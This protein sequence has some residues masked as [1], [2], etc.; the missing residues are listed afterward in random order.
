VAAGHCLQHHALRRVPGRRGFECLDALVDAAAD[1]LVGEVAEPAFHL[2]IQE[3]AVGVKWTWKRGAGRASSG[4][5]GSCACRSCRRPGTRPGLPGRFLSILFEEPKELLVPVQL[6]DHEQDGLLR[7]L[8]YM[9]TTSTTFSTDSGSVD[10]WKPSMRCGLTSNLRRTRPTVDFDRP[11]RLAIEARDQWVAFRGSS[12]RVAVTTSSTF[13]QQDQRDPPG[14]RLVGLADQ[15]LPDE[16]APPPG[17]RVLGSPQLGGG[18][19]LV[20][21]ARAGQHDLRP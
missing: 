6:A 17:H 1:L 14:A 18:P 16:L 4:S 21:A 20:P 10:S 19:P 3:N 15:A 11:L 13:V 12:S 5:P 8:W 2:V 7:R 9:P